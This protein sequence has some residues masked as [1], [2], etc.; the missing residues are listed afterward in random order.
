MIGVLV[1][2]KDGYELRQVNVQLFRPTQ[3][4]F[5]RDSAINHN[6]TIGRF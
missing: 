5:S 2:N 4:F 1:R 3:N 6:E